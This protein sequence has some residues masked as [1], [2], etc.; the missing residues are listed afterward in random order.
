MVTSLC[1]RLELYSRIGLKG[2]YACFQYQRRSTHCK[3][4]KQPCA[5]FCSGPL[6]LWEDLVGC[7]HMYLKALN[8]KC[9]VLEIRKVK[10]HLSCHCIKLPC[11]I[12]PKQFIPCASIGESSRCVATA[13]SSPDR[14]A[15][16]STNNSK[17][18]TT[19]PN[20]P[21][22]IFHSRYQTSV[23]QIDEIFI[24]DTLTITARGSA[25]TT[26]ITRRGDAGR[27]MH[28]MGQVRKG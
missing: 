1:Q 24:G 20:G 5:T 23:F 18:S 19:L 22:M 17:E 25:G 11:I 8:S 15:T 7:T 21:G 26:V 9:R 16:L 4:S 14:V 27:M 3:N 28:N 10:P 2:R 13:L 12:Q 6:S